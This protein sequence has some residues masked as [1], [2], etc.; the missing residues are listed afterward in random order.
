MPKDH[1]GILSSSGGTPVFEPAG[2]KAEIAMDVVDSVDLRIGTIVDVVPIP[3][4]NRLVTLIVDF[5]RDTRTVVAGIREERDDPR[6]LVGRQALFYY[7]VPSRT[8]RGQVSEAMLCDV[9]HADG[10]KPALL[11]P[12]WRV[13]NGTRAG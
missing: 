6:V 4:A 11:A 12:E 1:Q 7:N 10:I 2:Q 5:G 13:P 3:G 8:I 9:G